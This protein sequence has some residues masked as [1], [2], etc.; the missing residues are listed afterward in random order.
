MLHFFI[1]CDILNIC[2]YSERDNF[3]ELF[4]KTIKSDLIY[5]GRVFNVYSDRVILPDG[6]EADR[7]FIE[8]NGGVCILPLLDN[9]DVIFVKQFRYG[10]KDT[11]LEIPAGKREKNEDPRECGLR[12]LKEEI[13]AE[14]EEFIFLGE[15]LPTTAYLSER[16]YMYLAKGLHFSEQKLDDDEFLE[17]I[18]IPFEKA[19]EMVLSGEIKD[20]KTQIAL[21]KARM[22]NLV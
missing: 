16:I 11:L 19:I 7:E 20:A 21:M 3:M 12:E 4:E 2:I 13:G 5:N 15:C 14:A 18:H 6:R 22:K 10:I 17:I 8:H 1:E 9:G